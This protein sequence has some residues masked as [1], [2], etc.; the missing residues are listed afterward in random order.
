MSTTK[1]EEYLAEAESAPA[2][3]PVSEIDEKEIEQLYAALRS[4]TAK[5]VG[6][7]GRAQR[8]PNSLYSFLVELIRRLNEG[9]SIYIVQNQAK[10]STI[11][12][13][14][15]LG[16]SRQFLV[17]LLEKGEIPFHMVGTH[18]RIYAQ[19]LLSYKAKR[20]SKRRSILRDLA[21]AEVNDGIYDRVPIIRHDED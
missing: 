7:D 19:H 18:R 17:N 11:E 10:L 21:R 20:D 14:G 13:A 16:V 8:L 15:M 4:G 9:E 3:V 2:R 1:Q 12:A 5:L 6:P